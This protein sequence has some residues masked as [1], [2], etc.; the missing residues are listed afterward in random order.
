MHA[1]RFAL[2]LALAAGLSG[3][4]TIGKWFGAE[5]D[6]NAAGVP[7]VPPPRIEPNREE[8]ARL[9]LR[10]GIGYIQ[11]GDYAVAVEKLKKAI[12][13]DDSVAEA[14]NALGLAHERL[15]E[16]GAAEREYARAVELNP[17]FAPAQLNQA[18][19][20]CLRGQVGVG[21]KRL[22]AMADNPVGDVTPE[23][24]LVE[25]ASCVRTVAPERAEDYLR[26]AIELN[27]RASR[28]HYDL[29]VLLLDRGRATEARVELQRFHEL[30]GYSA[31]SLALGIRI[32]DA[33][34]DAALRR[35]YQT[36]LQ[37][38]FGGSPDARRLR[39]PR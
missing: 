10:L 19:L 31:E 7:Q 12:E 28:A 37:S 26:R 30:A 4:Q 24:A 23:T 36:L 21:E 15:R 25:A 3:C 39:P 17:N 2:V 27:P 34:G 20:A 8:A 33:T 22:V 6:P 13:F 32:A 9:N 5:E 11:S 35:E 29:A 18:R 38:R 1:F 14:H 16:L